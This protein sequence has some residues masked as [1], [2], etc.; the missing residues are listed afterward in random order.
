MVFFYV[1]VLK[2][3]VDGDKY[4]GFTTRLRKRI[5][6]HQQGKNF[7]TM[8]RR[9]FKLVYFEACLSEEDAK[10]RERYLK[11]TGGKRFLAKTTP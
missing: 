8:F 11:T 9:P 4:V 7:S 3:L 1:Y 5:E 2:S 10:R 6:E